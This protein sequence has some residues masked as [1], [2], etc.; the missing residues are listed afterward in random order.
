LLLKGVVTATYVLDDESH[1]RADK[2]GKSPNGPKVVY[3]DV[4]CYSNISGF[5]WRAIPTCLVLQKSASIHDG[6]PWVPRAT[7]KDITGKTLDYERGGNPADFDGDHVL[8]GFAS[9][10][11]SEPIILGGIS[12][13][14]SDYGNEESEVRQRLQLRLADGD[15]RYVKH[16]GTIY[17]M[18]SDGNFKVDSRYAHDGV[19]D[20]SGKE[21]AP[22][23][24]GKGAQTFD[25]PLD[26]EYTVRLWDMTNANDQGD[27][28]TSPEEKARLKISK[29]RVEVVYTDSGLTML[30]DDENGVIELGAEGAGDSLVLTSKADSEH[31]SIRDAITA[32][33][34]ELEQHKHATSMYFV[35]LIP[36]P[37]KPIDQ[38]IAPNVTANAN[39]EA[40]TIL[41]S[42]V[43]DSQLGSPPV[44]NEADV[45]TYNPLLFSEGGSA[46]DV[47]STRVTTDQ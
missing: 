39:N 11:F 27:G 35:P 42:G 32:L 26:A 44:S 40:Q 23:T 19:L 25:L 30:I 29:N 17:G 4:L 5:R 37:G 34:E 45:G 9:N 33:S 43:E 21:P 13:P 31:G 36:N 3:C 47:A 41:P 22:S 46:G 28:N 15:P 2:T 6:E 16:H 18:D 38:C 8:V 10:S 1:P 12:H 7:K 20:E 24:E 14:K